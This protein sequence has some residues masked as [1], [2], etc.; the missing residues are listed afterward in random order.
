MRLVHTLPPIADWYILDNDTPGVVLGNLDSGYSAPAQLPI[1]LSVL[2]G[3][4]WNNSKQL[5]FDYAM[6]MELALVQ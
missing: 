4:Q 2:Y 6:N 5:V 3:K 1:R